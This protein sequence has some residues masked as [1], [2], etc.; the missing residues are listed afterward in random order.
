MIVRSVCIADC[1][2]GKLAARSRNLLCCTVV[3]EG[4]MHPFQTT[5]SPM[6]ERLKLLP[7]R[8]GTRPVLNDIMRLPVPWAE[9]AQCRYHIIVLLQTE[10]YPCVLPVA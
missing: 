2:L 10:V 8:D 7:S 4:L 5:A 6:Y 1:Q 3:R 9:C